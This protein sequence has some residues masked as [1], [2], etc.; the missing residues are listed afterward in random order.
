MEALISEILPNYVDA[1]AALCAALGGFFAGGALVAFL[2]W[3]IG[4]TVNAVF[5]WLESWT[6]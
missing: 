4:Y 6:R 1:V 5:G 3:V 2:A